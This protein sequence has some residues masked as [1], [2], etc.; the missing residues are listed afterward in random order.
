MRPR[1]GMTTPD[2]LVGVSWNIALPG[3]SS[4]GAM[5]SR[6]CVVGVISRVE[7]E[8]AQIRRVVGV[9]HHLPR[10]SRTTTARAGSRR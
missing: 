9:D 1:Q 5:A 6:S 10:P 7:D 2:T 8:L 3:A 4:T